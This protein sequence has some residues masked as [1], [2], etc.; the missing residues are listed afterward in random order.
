MS[1]TLSL[2]NRQR[3]RRVDTNLLRRVTKFLIR[4]PLAIGQFEL[5]IHLVTAAEMAQVNQKFLNHE[6]STD[7]ITFDYGSSALVDGAG[8]PWVPAPHSTLAGELFISIDDALVHA[9]RFRTT[10]QSELTRY[11][12][13][14]LL[15]LIGFDDKDPV[16]RARMK[17]EE[18][19][20]LDLVESRFALARLESRSGSQT[21]PRLVRGSRRVSRPG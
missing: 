20:M 9:R 7:V 2:R 19:R 14:G 18:N 6:G 1:E 11:V 13:H 4:E 5:A 3:A 10:W 8:R 15:H 17:A 16:C 21:G 12:I